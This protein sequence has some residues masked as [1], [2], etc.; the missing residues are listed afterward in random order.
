MKITD[1]LT[2]DTDGMEI[3]ADAHGNNVAFCCV[4]CGHPV[5]AISPE[6]QRGSDEGHPARCK[7]CGMRYYL[8]VRPQVAKL[9]IHA[10]DDGSA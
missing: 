4:E 2:M 6:N 3:P 8:D 7:G 10:V 1:F 9:Y 5:L